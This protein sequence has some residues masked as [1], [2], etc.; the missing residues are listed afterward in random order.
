MRGLL[1]KYNLFHKSFVRGEV[2]WNV[3]QKT[4]SEPQLAQY[5]PASF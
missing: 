5:G 1:C 2:T 4:T 3:M